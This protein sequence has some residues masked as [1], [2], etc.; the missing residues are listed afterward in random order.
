MLHVHIFLVV[1][2]GD[3]RMTQPGTDQ[4]EGRVA[5]WKTAY[6]TGAAADLPV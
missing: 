1:S 4:H 3:G 5:V 2:L 6:H